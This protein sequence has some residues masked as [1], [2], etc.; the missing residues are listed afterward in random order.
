MPSEAFFW[1]SRAAFSSRCDGRVEVPSSWRGRGFPVK[2]AAAAAQ[3]E[4]L[5]E[6]ERILRKQPKAGADQAQ[7]KGSS[8]DT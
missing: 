8:R 5:Q 3:G 7:K 1:L 6:K 2:E 4:V